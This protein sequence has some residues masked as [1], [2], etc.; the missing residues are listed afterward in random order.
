MAR[1][2]RLTKNRHGTF[3]LRVV[4]PRALRGPTGRPREVRLSL[5]TRD[6][7]RARILALQ[8]NLKLEQLKAMTKQNPTPP[9]GLEY[10]TLTMGNLKVDINSEEDH[11]LFQ[12]LLSDNEELRDAMLQAVRTGTAPAGV[13]QLMTQPPASRPLNP[14][15]LKDA[16]EL[17]ES[18]RGALNQNRRSTAGEKR[19]T[20]DLM[21]AHLRSTGLRD[22]T[23]Y[24]HEIRR[25]Q[26]IA[27]LGVYANRRGKAA[28]AQEADGV[29]APQDQAGGK[30]EADDTDANERLSARTVV[31]AVGHLSNFFIFAVAQ[32]WAGANPVDDAFLKAMEGLRKAASKDRNAHSYEL[33]SQE[34]LRRVFAPAAYLRGLN[35]AD[36]FWA[37]LIAL[38][39]GAR[40]GEIVLL[41]V[42]S[43]RYD[44]EHGVHLID[45][46]DAVAG[47]RAAKNQNS[48]RKVPV[49][50]QLIHLGFLDY[51]DH[52]RGLGATLLFPHRPL[53][54]TRKSDPSKH[55]SRAFGEHLDAI[56][57]DSPSKVFHSLRHTVITYLH[58]NSVPVGDAELIVGHAAQEMHARIGAVTGSGGSSQTHMNTYV[59][60][61]QFSTSAVGL[62][63]R[64]KQHMDRALGYD[65]DVNGLREAARIVQD[66]TVKRKDGSFAS[67]W[68]TNAKA[69][70]AAML[71][72]LVKAAPGTATAQQA[73]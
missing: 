24:V 36:E 21:R 19:R 33:F 43:I 55:V 69:T 47:Q 70:A 34:E 32:N 49:P 4:V 64:L 45:I 16:I 14:I 37:P 11:R 6:L 68:H 31:K 17:Y 61:A 54:A 2:A 35:A 23:L 72:R 56:G 46:K 30:A 65:L 42:A 26:L 12:K 1:T 8:F 66:R 20:L 7:V 73:D 5:R 25:D 50:S 51:C 63:M 58:V 9:Q 71:A 62:Y 52:V 57:I 44:D 28:L 41:E 67:G 18:T 38:F 40:L 53:N 39:T 22:E 27:F 10:M 15:L 59:N 48:V 13:Q 3:T 60:S 29:A